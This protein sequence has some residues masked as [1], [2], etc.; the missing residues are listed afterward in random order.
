VAEG[1]EASLRVK[2]SNAR[3]ALLELLLLLLALLA[4]DLR[5][6]LVDLALT[7]AII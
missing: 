5:F 4:L 7:A 6:G 2:L 1:C 3:A